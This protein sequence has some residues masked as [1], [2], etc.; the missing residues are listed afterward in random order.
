MSGRRGLSPSLFARGKSIGC[1]QNRKKQIKVSTI[2][3]PCSA[4]LSAFHSTFVRLDGRRPENV[5]NPCSED[6]H[7]R[8]IIDK[9]LLY[10][11]QFLIGRPDDSAKFH[12]SYRILVH[13]LRFLS[14]APS[15]A[16]FGRPFASGHGR[17]TSHSV[18]IHA[19]QK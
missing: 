9:N 18:S 4:F 7:H 10:Y 2:S 8:K 17:A 14:V 13:L 15:R 1:L 19:R 11:Y 12:F 6:H 5:C 3:I 16:P